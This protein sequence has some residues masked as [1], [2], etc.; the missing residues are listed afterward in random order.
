[1]P[2]KAEAA[3]TLSVSSVGSVPSVAPSR[4]TSSA[5]RFRAACRDYRLRQAFITP[6]TPEQNGIVE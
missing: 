3:W 2:I 6:Y 1:M 4:A 5:R